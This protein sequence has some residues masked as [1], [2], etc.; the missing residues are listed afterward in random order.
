MRVGQ[1]AAIATE[2][3]W[4]IADVEEYQPTRRMHSTTHLFQ[5]G[6]GYAIALR[7]GKT[8]P[9]AYADYGP[10]TAHKA[11]RGWVVFTSKE[12]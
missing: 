1:R 6:R 4:D 3:G 2:F 8:I 12:T 5:T 7:E 11:H 9:K 10:W